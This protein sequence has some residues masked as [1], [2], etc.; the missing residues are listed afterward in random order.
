MYW[1]ISHEIMI[2]NKGDY[3]WQVLGIR[4]LLTSLHII[5]LIITWLYAR[6][7]SKG[8]IITSDL[9]SQIYLQPLNPVAF[10]QPSTQYFHLNI[11]SSFSKINHHLQKRQF[12]S[13]SISSKNPQCIPRLLSLTHPR[14]IPSSTS[15]LSLI[16]T[17]NSTVYQPYFH[18]RYM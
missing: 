2:P 11:S 9:T 4:E 17:Q 14:S 15:A 5:S 16:Y 6:M 1:G 10:V 12:H 3:L 18:L 7:E 13:L 8:W